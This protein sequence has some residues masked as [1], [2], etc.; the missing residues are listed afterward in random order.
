[1]RPL[2]MAAGWVRGSQGWHG[3]QTPGEHLTRR[4][5]EYAEP[6]RRPGPAIFTCYQ[7][8]RSVTPPVHD[9][10]YFDE[11]PVTIYE[12]SFRLPIHRGLISNYLFYAA[13]NP[14]IPLSRH[15]VT[16]CHAS[17]ARVPPLP[18]QQPAANTIFIVRAY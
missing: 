9:L 18:A 5:G 6:N 3:R 16:T 4:F 2:C 17:Y 13:A 12:D 14:H 1:M 10:K 7:P 8:P 11:W 15:A